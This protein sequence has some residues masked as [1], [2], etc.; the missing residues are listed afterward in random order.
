MPLTSETNAIRLDR[1]RIARLFARSIRR[2][3][4]AI[5]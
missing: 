1:R 2:Y 5:E 4:A 3:G